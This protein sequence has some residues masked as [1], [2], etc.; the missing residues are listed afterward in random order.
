MRW[1]V[2]PLATGVALLL[3]ATGVTSQASIEAQFESGDHGR[4][5][6]APQHEPAPEKRFRSD[7]A[8]QALVLLSKASVEV[9]GSLVISFLGKEDLDR[10]KLECMVTDSEKFAADVMEMSSN[11]IMMLQTGLGMNGGI[12]DVHINAL[13]T[14]KGQAP[15]IRF[16]TGDGAAEVAETSKNLT[17]DVVDIKVALAKAVEEEHYMRAARLKKELEAIEATIELKKQTKKNTSQSL[18]VFYGGG[19]RLKETELQA[20][21]KSGGMLMKASAVFIDIGVTLQQVVM[22]AHHIGENC[23]EGDTLRALKTAAKHMRD[24]KY[25]AGHFLANGADVV[26]ELTDCVEAYHSHNFTR[27]G[28]DI[29]VALRKVLLSHDSNAMPEAIMTK[30]V[31]A[32]IAQGLVKGFFGKGFVLNVQLEKDALDPLHIDI[33]ACIANNMLF[34]KEVFSSV[35]YLYSQKVEEEAKSQGLVRQG[36]QEK[37]EQKGRFGT[38]VALAMM[39]LPDALQ[40]CGLHK[41]QSDMLVDSIKNFGEGMQITV[42]TP[43]V[44]P[45]HAALKA[46]LHQTLKD[47]SELH[48]YQ[49]GFDVGLLLQEMLLTLFPTEYSFDT[50]GVL[51]KVLSET[52][53]PGRLARGLPAMIAVPGFLLAAVVVVQRVRRQHTR[54]IDHRDVESNPLW[55]YTATE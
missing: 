42:Q 38:A 50:N 49:F 24:V 15:V 9:I 11:L 5:L 55:E 13:K 1:S 28:S 20:A 40:K 31:M 19:R 23:L 43:N 51:Q 12:D 16:Q 39:Q 36:A 3:A 45:D 6:S 37:R 35:M 2:F 18:D 41:G 34:F 30:E 54:V 22:L 27:F 10:E 4:A 33:E 48:W 26:E 8:D 46:N 21:M 14:L 17:Q 44:A 47:W 32:D 52:P 25:I 29:G 7:A 53:V